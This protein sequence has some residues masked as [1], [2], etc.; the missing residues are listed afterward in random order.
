[1][2]EYI[3]IKIMKQP[4]IATVQLFK[5]KL[6]ELCLHGQI[7]DSSSLSSSDEFD[8]TVKNMRMN[9]GKIEREKITN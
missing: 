5:L 8:K 1:M 2:K 9:Q 7:N 4:C 6:P 3:L